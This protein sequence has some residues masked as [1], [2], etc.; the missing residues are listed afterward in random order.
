MLIDDSSPLTQQPHPVRDTLPANAAL[1]VP[2]LF[3]ERPPMSLTP[4]RSLKVTAAA[5]SLALGLTVTTVPEALA[6]SSQPGLSSQA[7]GGPI[8][9]SHV[10]VG[11]TATDMNFSWRTAYNGQEFVKYYPTDAPE[12]V[13]EVA[14]TEADFGAIAYRANHATVTGLQPGTEYTYQLGSEQGGWSEAATFRTQPAGDSWNFLT[15]SDAQIGVNLKVDEQAEAWR[16]AVRQAT[17]AYPD[18]QFIVHAGDQAE[19]WGDPI[20]Q[21][22]AFFT[23]EELQSYPLAMAKGNHELLPTSIVDKHFKEHGN[24]P[25]AKPGDANYFF[26][27]NNALFIVL[28]SNETGNKYSEPIDSKRKRAIEKQS[29]F[30]RET[31][32]AHGA[33]KDWTIVVMHHAPYSHGGRYHEKEI[34]QMREGLAPV[35]SETGV[36]LVL[37]GHDHMYNRSHLMNGTEPVIPEA[38]PAIGDVL[39][40]KANETVYMTTTTAG[41]GKYYDFHT[42]DGKKRKEFTDVSQTYGKDFA[43]PEIA[44]WRQDYNPDYAN[45]EVSKNTLTVRTHNVADNSVVDEFTIDRSGAAP[46]QPGGGEGNRSSFGS[47]GSSQRNS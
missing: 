18:S 45:I 37:N 34:T 28:D 12:A 17:G 9:S 39:R 1:P 3:A 6:Q 19:G 36:D 15:L 11:A 27:R 5:M 20:K 13:N 29:Q 43:I 22:E 21:W 16:T 23:A 25:N 30:V 35:F 32:A 33:D 41:G 26:E 38:T 10:H 46:A 14:A 42:R 31:T 24:L 47:S 8:S 7:A 2:R 4:A 40:P 44:V